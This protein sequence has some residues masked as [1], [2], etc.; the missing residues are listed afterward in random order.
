MDINHYK[1]WLQAPQARKKNDFEARESDFQR[2]NHIKCY[3]IQRKSDLT[4]FEK[5]ISKKSRIFGK[6]GKLI[7]ISLRENSKGGR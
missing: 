5:L 1:F 7:N 4:N 3:R 6:L 2:Q